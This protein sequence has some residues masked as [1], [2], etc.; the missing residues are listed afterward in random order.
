MALDGTRDAEVFGETGAVLLFDEV[1]ADW[2]DCGGE[3]V[4]GYR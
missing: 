1:V 4:I 3:K 2:G